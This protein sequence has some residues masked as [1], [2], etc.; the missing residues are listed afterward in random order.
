MRACLSIIA[1][2][3]ASTA[4]GAEPAKLPNVVLILADDLGYGDLGCYGS[5]KIKTPNIDR[6]AAEGTRFTS[7]YVSQPVCTASRASLLT[8]C[9]ANRVSMAGALNH[10]SKVGI[11]PDERLLQR[12]AQDEGL[13]D[14]GLRQVAPRRPPAVPAHQARLRRLR[15][16]AVLERQRPAPPDHAGPPAAAVLPRRQGRR[17]GPGPGAVHPAVHRPG[18]RVHREEHSTSRSSC[19]SRT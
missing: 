12:D 18:G 19:T 1:V 10:Q 3:F 4:A 14:R 5:K 8:G 2:G 15:R 11:H 9:Y 17:D 7:F 16:A 13:R 6:L